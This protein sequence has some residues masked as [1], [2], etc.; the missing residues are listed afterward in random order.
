MSSAIA[1]ARAAAAGRGTR[2]AKG[3]RQTADAEFAGEPPYDPDFDGP[4]RGGAGR[5]GVAQPPATPAYEGFDP[6]DEPLDE[7]VDEKTA[8]ESSEEQAVRLLR[9][10]F[11]TVEKISD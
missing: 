3:V 4:L 2:T 11:G 1:A 5:P 10:A 6:G 7:I 8:R 9:D